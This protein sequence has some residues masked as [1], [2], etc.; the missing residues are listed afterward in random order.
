MVR[1]SAH[2][3]AIGVCRPRFIFPVFKNNGAFY[4][5]MGEWQD[6][7]LILTYLEHYKRDPNAAEP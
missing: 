5:L 1:H 6:N 4:M 2:C 7:S 3:A